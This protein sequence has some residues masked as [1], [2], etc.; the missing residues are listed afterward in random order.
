MSKTRTKSEKTGLTAAQERALVALLSTP[1]NEMAAKQA[2]LTSRTLRRYLRTPEFQAEYLARRREML[3]HAIALAQ[4]H[5][6]AM[7]AVQISIAK[8]ATMPASVRVSAANNVYGIGDSGL[9][10]EDL[11]VRIAQLEGKFHEIGIKTHGNGTG[12]GRRLL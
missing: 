4:Q 8:D 10:T 1:T 3:S 11:E 12:S 2:G 5:A 9:K 7:V 6:A